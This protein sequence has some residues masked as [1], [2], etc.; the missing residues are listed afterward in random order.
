MTLKKF[1]AAAVIAFAGLGGAMA[2]QGDFY[3]GAR[4]QYSM[5]SFSE[6]FST[7]LGPDLT[8]KY[9]YTSIPEVGFDLV[10]GYQFVA[11][12]RAELNYGQAG[13]YVVNDEEDD[14][15]TRWLLYTRYLMANAL[16][17]AWT[18]DSFNV[19]VGGGIGAAFMK[20]RMV[21]DDSDFNYRIGKTRIAGQFIAGISQGITDW[22]TLDAQFR[23]MYNDGLTERFD[24]GGGYYFDVKTGDVLTSSLML[25]ARVVF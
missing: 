5:L 8:E 13:R 10:A 6:E 9:F 24:I 15:N 16:Y 7:N 14:D 11:K 4:A 12:W 3:I 22:L 18:E 19:Y 1:I 17:T 2:E 20:A 23:V 25:G 21:S